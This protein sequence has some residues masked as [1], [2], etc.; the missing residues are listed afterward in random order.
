MWDHLL[1]D[2]R[3]IHSIVFPMISRKKQKSVT[4]HNYYKYY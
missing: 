3:N 4:I 1:F 2:R